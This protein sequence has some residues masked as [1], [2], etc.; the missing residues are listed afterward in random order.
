MDIAVCYDVM[1]GITAGGTMGYLQNRLE[2]QKEKKISA[3]WTT[4]SLQLNHLLLLTAETLISGDVDLGAYGLFTKTVY[5]LSPIIF[6]Y[7]HKIKQIIPSETKALETWNN[8]YYIG[9]LANSIATG[10]LGNSTFAAASFM[11][12]GVNTYTKGATIGQVNKVAAICA[13]MGYGF[14]V[15]F[16]PSWMAIFGT[17]STVVTAFKIILDALPE[18]A[19]TPRSYSTGG[20]GSSDYPDPYNSYHFHTYN[21]GGGISS[22]WDGSTP[23]TRRGAWS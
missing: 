9:I 10:V 16:S 3:A 14:Q 23:V 22:S 7:E 19:D 2:Q 20:S 21:Y 1:Q 17:P 5:V 11:I 12:I 18:E 13:S 15:M 4:A 8:L 6:F